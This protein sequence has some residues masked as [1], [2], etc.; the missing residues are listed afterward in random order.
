MD[1][2]DKIYPIVSPLKLDWAKLAR[3]VMDK[4]EKEVA[5]T[6]HGKILK[7]SKN[8]RHLKSLDPRNQGKTK[9]RIGFTKTKPR[10]KVGKDFV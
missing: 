5:M 2:R 7:Q 4:A 6:Q 9:R 8:R 10:R 1:I 3:Q